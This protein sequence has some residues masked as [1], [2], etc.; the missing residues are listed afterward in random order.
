MELSECYSDY[1]HLDKNFKE[2][3]NLEDDTKKGHLWTRFIFTNHF[4]KMLEDISFI[5]SDERV[6][7]RKG[8][9]LTGKYG[10]GKSH[11]TAVLSHLLWDDPNDIQSILLD[12]KD[13]MEETGSV[14]YLFRQ[15]KRYFPVILSAQDSG[16]VEDTKSFEYSLQIALEA[17]LKREGYLEKISSSTEFQKYSLWLQQMRDDPERR[18]LLDIIDGEIQKGTAFADIDELIEALDDRDIDALKLIQDFFK[19]YDIPPPRHCDTLGYYESVLADLKKCDPTIQGIVIYWDEFTTVFNAAGKFRDA[20]LIDRIQT[21]AEKAQL[22]IYLF[23]VSHLSPEALRGRYQLLEDALAKI[24][25]RLCVTDIRMDKKTTYHLIAES[26]RVNDRQALALFLSRLGFSAGE[27]A[28]LQILGRQIFGDAFQQ[29]EQDIKKTIPLHLYS[30]YVA[31]KIADLVGSAERSIFSLIHSD[32]HETT[33]YGEKIGFKYFLD[34]EPSEKKVTWYTLDRVFDFFFEDLAAHE[35]DPVADSNIIKPINAFKQYYPIAQQ[36]GDDGVRVFKALALL[37]MLYASTNDAPLIPTLKNLKNAFAMTEISNVKEI[38][39][40]MIEKPIIISYEDEQSGGT[41]Y[42]TVYGGYDDEERN[43]LK[44]DLKDIHAFEKF[45]ADNKKEILKKIKEQITDA[46]RIASDNCNITILPAE[47]IPKRKEIKDLDVDKKLN[48]I[49][50]IPETPKEFD[51]TRQDLLNLSRSHKNVI[52]ALYEG[53]FAKRYDRW[54]SA[55]ALSL[56]GQKRSNRSMIAEAQKEEKSEIK[57]LLDDLNRVNIFFRGESITKPNG[58]GNETSKYIEQIYPLGFDHLKYDQFW[59]SPKK[60]SAEIAVFYGE[61]NARQNIE[62]NNT[63]YVKKII[64]LFKDKRNNTLVGETL[65]LKEDEDYTLNSPLYTIVTKIRNHI[66]KNNG[67]WLS[68]RGLIE[69]LDLEVPPYG[70]CGWIESL[71]LTYALAEFIEEGRLEVMAGNQTPTKDTAKIIEAINAATKKDQKDSQIRYGRIIEN[72]T[73]KKL[74]EILDL[75]IDKKSP[76]PTVLFKIREKINTVYGLPIWTIPLALNKEEQ[77]DYEKVIDPLNR[78]LLSDDKEYSEE[79]LNEVMDQIT[80]T[81]RKHSKKIWNTLFTQET[82]RKGFKEYVYGYYPRL[83]NVYPED[84]SLIK[85]VYK[86]VKPDPWTWE[87]SQISDVLAQ[88][89]RTT[90]PPEQPRNV[91]IS[92]DAE[93][94]HIVWD[95]P[96]VDAPQPDSYDILRSEDPEQQ[97][98]FLKRIDATTTRYCDQTTRPGQTY[99]YQIFAR[100]AAGESRASETVRQKILLPAPQ[101][102]LSVHS[103]DNSITI[104]WETPSHPEQYGIVEYE[105]HAGELPNSLSKVAWLQADATSYQ[106]YDVKPGKTYYFQVITKNSDGER[107]KGQISKPVRIRANEPPQKPRE[108]KALISPDGVEITWAHPESGIASV[109]EYCIYREDESGNVALRYNGTPRDTRFTDKDLCPGIYTYSVMARNKAGESEWAETAAVQIFPEIPPLSLTVEDKGGKAHL[110]WDLLEENYGIVRYQI[111]RG[112]TPN[113]IKP[114]R[115]CGTDEDTFIDESVRPGHTYYYELAA[116][117]KAQATRKTDTPL[118]F[119]PNLSINITKWEDETRE[120]VKSNPELF[121]S[122]LMTVLKHISNGNGTS[123]SKEHEKI[124]DLLEYLEGLSDARI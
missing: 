32:A 84:E 31:A 113:T 35:F 107:G 30:V 34:H 21:W 112:E 120:F 54:L 91:H 86:E 71:I 64:E 76:L 119:A 40:R 12:A 2:V 121:I 17:S 18:G 90:D 105:I 38:L 80:E 24:D 57:K 83:L 36:I 37:E 9:L 108:V 63:Y 101:L 59:G 79:L 60:N 102:A 70:L 42:K 4:K 122:Q 1:I 82:L 77:Q 74:I 23:L 55:R 13:R 10:V 51:R 3:F 19:K 100:N 67:K 124:V 110:H 48:L 16:R 65:R 66:Q 75:D 99:A 97:C 33:P 89:N 69:D 114:L 88:L 5:F 27:Y 20:N 118:K 44:K 92:R 72:K 98:T 95:S 106:N 41:I 11:A 26:L 50:C 93:G 68:I 28:N 116:T 103:E 14:L 15:E 78:L 94:V 123:A 46:P 8:I 45:I 6:N 56:L 53:S 104:S 7:E 73:A 117:N 61:A 52:F 49:V 81:E 109:D 22:G 96:S 25:D 62:R 85:V 47:N 43:R 115:S 58:F 39:D 111:Y 29:D 87:K